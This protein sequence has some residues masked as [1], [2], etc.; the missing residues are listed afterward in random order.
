ME[1]IE[2]SDR[3]ID[4]QGLRLAS[5]LRSTSAD[6]IFESLRDLPACE[7]GYIES[8][9]TADTAETTLNIFFSP[10]LRLRMIFLNHNITTFEFLSIQIKW[11]TLEQCG[12]GNDN[13]ST[14]T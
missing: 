9:C 11:F 7:Y 13:I 8:Y 5:S 4:R 12:S 1:T 10:L 3:D 2:W 6:C 14:T